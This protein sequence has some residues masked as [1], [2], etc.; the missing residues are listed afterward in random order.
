MIYLVSINALAF[1][2]MSLDKLFAKKHRRRIPE[3]MLLSIAAIGGSL[4]AILAMLTFHHKT[5]HVQFRVGLPVFLLI[6]LF[7]LFMFRYFL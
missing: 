6:H 5:R 3:S 4:G 2:L 1:V 7:I